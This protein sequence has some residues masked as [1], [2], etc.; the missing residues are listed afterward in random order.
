MKKTTTKKSN[1][2]LNTVLGVLAGAAVG[3]LFYQKVI[4]KNPQTDF[5]P[6]PTPTPSTPT[7]SPST[8]P[9]LNRTK[10]LKKG[11]NGAETKELQRLLGV[12]QDGIFGNL[13]ETALVKLKGVVQTTLIQF[14][15]APNVNQNALKVG[16][17]IMAGTTGIRVI[18]AIREANGTYYQ[19]TTTVQIGRGNEIGT[20]TAMT[21]AKDFF[22]VDSV[23]LPVVGRIKVF[24]P[25]NQV[26]KI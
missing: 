23:S 7:P 6:E 21:P 9:L 16:D 2:T 24:V 22:L 19:G 4:K 3:T 18:Q 26:I 25:A 13:T 17:R 12:S 5:V 1:K 15:S 10:L 11:V 20:I 14:S 8:S